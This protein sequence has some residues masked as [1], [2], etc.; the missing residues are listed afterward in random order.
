MSGPLFVP[1]ASVPIPSIE[2]LAAD[3][4]RVTAERDALRAALQYCITEPGAAAY[5]RNREWAARRLDSITA[6]ARDA[7]AGQS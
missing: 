2:T 3:F 1:G 4:A 7:L 5:T 6:T